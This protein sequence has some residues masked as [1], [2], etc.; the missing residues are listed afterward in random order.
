VTAGAAFPGGEAKK[1][2]LSVAP[3]LELTGVECGYSSDGCSVN[4][5][6]VETSGTE[7]AIVANNPITLG[8]KELAKLVHVTPPVRGLYVYSYGGERVV[9]SGGFERSKHYDVT[10]VGLVDKY[11]SRLEKPFHVALERSPED[12]SVAMASGVLLLDD[13]KMRRF[14]ITTRNVAEARLWFWPVA[15]KDLASAVQSVRSGVAPSDTPIVSLPVPIHA[16]ENELVTTQVDLTKTLV[17]GRRYL[18]TPRVW[19]TS[20]GAELPRSEMA[21]PLALLLPAGADSLAVHVERRAS[22]AVIHVA[23]LGTG[24]PIEGALVSLLGRSD[25]EPAKTNAGGLAM[26]LGATDGLLDVRAGEASALLDLQKADTTAAR[27]F[28]RFAAGSDAPPDERALVFTDRGIYRPGGTV[29]AFATVRK[30]EGPRLAPVKDAEVI[31]RALGPSGE[32]VFRSPMTT[33]DMGSVAVSFDVAKDGKLGRHRVLVERPGETH[34]A[35]AEAIV[36]VAEFEAP[37]FA[38]DVDA[39]ATDTKTLRAS[40]FAK[41]LFGAPMDG[42]YV[43]WT[44]RREPA[45]IDEGPFAGRGFSFRPQREPSEDAGSRAAW[46]RAGV[47]LTGK[48][49]VALVEQRLSLDGA[50]GPQRFV[51]EAQVTDSSHR[52]IAGRASAIVHPAE[53]YAGVRVPQRWTRAGAAVPVELAVVDRDGKAVAGASVSAVLSRVEYLSVA[54]RDA[55][56]A[57]SY[58]WSRRTAPVGRCRATSGTS[59]ATCDL[60]MPAEGDYEIAAEIDGHSGGSTTVWAWNGAGSRGPRAPDRGRAL[61]LVADKPS[62]APGD[63]AKLFVTSPFEAATAIV[64]TDAPGSMPRAQRIDGSAGEIEIPVTAADAPHV[65]AMVTLL[66]LAAKGGAVADY[67]FGAARLPVTLTGARLALDVTPSKAS[68]APRDEVEIALRAS[69]GASPAG[70]AEIAI[71]VVDEGVLRLTGFHAPDPVAELRPGRALALDLY[72]TRAA[73]ADLVAQS[74]VAGDGDGDSVG[75]S[76][77]GRRGETDRSLTSARRTFADTA[78]WKPDVRTGEDGRATV[79]FRL[80]DNLTEYRVMAVA[81][82]RDGKGAVTETSFTVTKPLLLAPALPRFVALGDTFEAAALLHRPLTKTAKRPGAGDAS[83][84]EAAERAAGDRVVVAFEG[85]EKVVHVPPGGHARVGFPV[86]VTCEDDAKPGEIALCPTSKDGQP[87]GLRVAF[88]ARGAD[89][90]VLDAVEQRLPASFAGLDEAP[91]VDGS[92]R[93]SRSIALRVPAHVSPRGAEDRLVIALG[94]QM[95]PELGERLRFLL[96]YPHGCVEQTTSSTLPLLAARDIAPRIGMAMVSDADLQTKIRAG[97]ARLATMRTPG[98]GLA[99]WPGGSEPNT[100]GTA[101]AMRALVLAKAAGI[102]PPKEL[103]DGMTAYLSE[104]ML[105]R[106]YP[107]EVQAAIAQ[108]L[109]ELGKLDPGAS[110]ALY[111]RKDEQ[112]VFGAA[113]LAIALATLPGQDDRVAALLDRVEAGIGE[114]GELLR[115]PSSEDFYYYGSPQRTKAQAAIALRKLRPA[116]PKLPLLVRALASATESYTTQ[117][118]A[119]SLLALAEEVRRLSIDASDAAVLLD[120]KELAPARELPG[121]GKQ[122]EIA[123][124]SLAGREATLELRSASDEAVGFVVRAAWR[125]PAEEISTQP[126][127]TATGPAV[128]RVYTDAKGQPVDLASVRAGDVLRVALVARRPPAVSEERYGYVALTDRLPAGFEPVQ[129]DLAT[130]AAQPDAGPSHPFAAWFQ[131]ADER[132]SFLEMHDDRVS[133][134]FDRTSGDDVVATYLVRATTPGSFAIPPATAELMYEPGSL[135]ASAPERVAVR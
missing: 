42:A 29:R 80:P 14:E 69:D 129:Q 82:D 92:F 68:Y 132:P 2:V 131:H 12:A 48:D 49:G 3:P 81:L 22:Q 90:A 88:E 95:W 63:T 28:P 36:Q 103:L 109:A 33:S 20:Y 115:A 124:A 18:A 60:V 64:S 113:S 58:D 89:G 56:G 67:R 134:Y 6:T 25:A 40:V 19:Q 83:P 45:K 112:T 50:A 108:S 66:P 27:L 100:F 46:A 114:A 57:V 87:A 52:A 127:Q 123:L 4:E 34:E 121:G 86:R 111:D 119:Y 118:T 15:D 98:G 24:E 23:K 71:A 17:A 41:Y 32:E 43:S 7:L 54:R 96:D 37:R 130:V 55:G 79:R 59:A 120:G 133:I 77:R 107:A 125:R 97:L 65:H 16:Q 78:F 39:A 8:E 13:A 73:I 122:F 30:A 117:A 47:T 9:I 94:G 85:Q 105:A 62:Y 104:Q 51:V 61:D 126:F 74:H 44:A 70:G 35:L 76:T 128:Y 75:P 11:G 135:G 31:V 101:Y 116:S 110:D 21:K 91:R 38:V 26:F 93:K 72:D 99:Y 10:L 53:R 84:G 1:A 106:T 5:G 102:E